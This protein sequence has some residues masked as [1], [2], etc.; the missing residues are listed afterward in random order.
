MSLLKFAVE[1]TIPDEEQ[2]TIK[3]NYLM[4]TYEFIITN[5]SK[6]NSTDEDQNLCY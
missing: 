3:F 6:Q 1:T 2:L 4:Y 5:N